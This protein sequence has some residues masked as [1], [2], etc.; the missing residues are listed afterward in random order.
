M[1]SDLPLVGLVS[2]TVCDAF[3]WNS[4]DGETLINTGFARWWSS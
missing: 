3:G 2:V 4:G 1:F